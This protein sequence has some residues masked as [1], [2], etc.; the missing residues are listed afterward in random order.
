MHYYSITQFTITLSHNASLPKHQ[1][2]LLTTGCAGS[3][4]SV[5]SMWLS[6]D[7]LHLYTLAI[8]HTIKLSIQ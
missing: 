1:I 2:S 4:Y 8:H 7:K 5:P 6:L 3:V